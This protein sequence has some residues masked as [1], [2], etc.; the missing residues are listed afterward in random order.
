M[1]RNHPSKFGLNR[2]AGWREQS[3]RQTDWWTDR[4]KCQMRFSFAC[5]Q[6][7]QKVYWRMWLGLTRFRLYNCLSSGNKGGVNV[8]DWVEIPH[9]LT[10]LKDNSKI[11]EGKKLTHVYGVLLLYNTL[12][13]VRWEKFL[14][15]SDEINGWLQPTDEIRNVAGGLA[16]PSLLFLWDYLHFVWVSGA[17]VGRMGQGWKRA[18]Q[19]PLKNCRCAKRTQRRF[20]W[21]WTHKG[22]FSGHGGLY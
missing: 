9:L 4:Q 2:L 12:T 22:V 13:K 5:Y 18:S 6:I 17:V 3:D 14:I 20:E 11:L 7:C 8:A 21:N 1:L 19:T 15:K 10:I 16:S